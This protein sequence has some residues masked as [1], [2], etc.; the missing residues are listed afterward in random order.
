MRRGRRE[1]SSGRVLAVEIVPDP[2]TAPCAPAAALPRGRSSRP[3]GEQTRKGFPL[4]A[5]WW[6][7][8]EAEGPFGSNRSGI[9]DSLAVPPWNR[10]RARP[11][12]TH[13]WS[14]AARS[15]A[16]LAHEPSRTVRDP[17]TVRPP[18]PRVLVAGD[19]QTRGSG[20]DDQSFANRLGSLLAHAHRPK[21]VEVLDAGVRCSSLIE[22][23]STLHTLRF[24]AA[25]VHGWIAGGNGFGGFAS[26]RTWFGAQRPRTVGLLRGA[27]ARAS[28][29]PKP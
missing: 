8:G 19:S 7:A 27:L 13:R 5:H 6:A 22:C 20:A 4:G 1:R 3:G 26:V 9:L 18:E 17:R 14:T 21:T 12:H 2:K 10:G 11:A 28:L 23:Q 24:F 29:R 15:R 16:A 25:R